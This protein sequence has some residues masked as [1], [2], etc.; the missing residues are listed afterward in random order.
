MTKL[1]G[2]ILHLGAASLTGAKVMLD[3]VTRLIDIDGVCPIPALLPSFFPTCRDSAGP[4]PETNTT[5]TPYTWPLSTPCAG[6]GPDRYCVYSDPDFAHGHGI[7]VITTPARAAQLSRSRVFT[8]ASSS[9]SVSASF[10]ETLNAPSSPK[11]RV[12]PIA[13]K[14]QGLVAARALRPGDVIL[15]ETPSLMVDYGAWAALSA[16]DVR[17]LQAQGVGSLPGAHR[18]GFMGLSTHDEDGEGE[19][20]IRGEWGGRGMNMTRVEGVVE[21]IMETNA[22]DIY[23]AGEV[24]ETEEE[25][26]RTWYTVFGTISRMNHDCRPNAD[27]HFDAATLTHNIHAIAPIAPGEEITISY[28]DNIQPLAARQSH[29]QRTWHFQCTCAQCTQPGSLSTS[30]SYRLA[31]LIALRTSY[32]PLLY[33]NPSPLPSQPPSISFPTP[34]QAHLLLSLTAQER[35]LGTPLYEAHALAALAHSASGDAW[36][37]VREARLAEEWALVVGKPGDG[38]EV[39]DMR[40]LAGDPGGHWSWMWNRRGRIGGR[41]GGGERTGEDEE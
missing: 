4:G 23:H 37:A 2:L 9:F 5:T 11:W 13:G 27:Y 21:R 24:V 3:P 25:E 16:E 33:H 41:K 7:S 40:G 19:E 15:R 8:S 35:L 29:I 14:G 32:L 34:Q 20:E 36:G 12:Q 6:T 39:R 10:D 26:E 31:Q 30:S 22:F 17:R 38:A 28:I 18:V 1:S